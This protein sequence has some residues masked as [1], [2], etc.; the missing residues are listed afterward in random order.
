MF[1]AFLME[2]NLRDGV[3]RRTSRFGNNPM[4]GFR[5]T[6]DADTMIPS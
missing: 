5:R 4:A 3:L 6:P 2:R 1:I